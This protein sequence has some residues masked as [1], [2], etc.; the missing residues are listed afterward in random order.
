MAETT[1][2]PFMDMNAINLLTAQLEGQIKANLHKELTE[3]LVKQFLVEVEDDITDLVSRFSLDRIDKMRDVLH[4]RDE[5]RVW[6]AWKD[7]SGAYQLPPEYY[8]EKRGG[9]K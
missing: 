3:R 4:Y 9:T 6:L 5:L 1:L 8:S 2:G 7:K